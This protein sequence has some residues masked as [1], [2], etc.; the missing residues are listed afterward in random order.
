MNVNKVNKY[1]STVETT[2]RRLNKFHQ[3]H[4]LHTTFD[5]GKLIPI[6]LKEVLPNDVRKLKWSSVVRLLTPK[7][8][9]MDNA[10]IDTFFFYVR[11][12]DI[13]DDWSKFMG[14]N[15][16]PW[17]I[18]NEPNVPQIMIPINESS[19]NIGDL[20]DYLGIPAQKMSS[21]LTGN[22]EVNALPFRAVCKIWNDYFRDENYQSDLYFPRDSASIVYSKIS[23]I[24]VCFFFFFKQKTAYDIVM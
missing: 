19:R 7:F 23:A 18:S 17:A 9:T 2:T 1:T 13:W 6:Y 22:L 16:D 10:K 8:P 21:G 20:A 24:F 4:G 14:E 5:S 11:N 12:R 3:P 15:S